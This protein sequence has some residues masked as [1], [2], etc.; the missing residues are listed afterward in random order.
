MAGLGG[1]AWP[2]CLG[3]GQC[4]LSGGQVPT[5]AHCAFDRGTALTGGIGCNTHPVPTETSSAPRGASR[6]LLGLACLYSV[7][8]AGM[9]RCTQK[10]GQVW[11]PQH[12]H[13]SPVCTTQ[14]RG[15]WASFTVSNMAAT[16]EEAWVGR[17]A[18]SL[19]WALWLAH[20]LRSHSRTE[21]HT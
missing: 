6:G 19:G 8:R 16:R 10:E 5:P 17:E 1:A 11:R 18:C 7:A 20:P 3:K 9:G 15:T 2:G 12:W 21:V 13:S 14:A 4:V